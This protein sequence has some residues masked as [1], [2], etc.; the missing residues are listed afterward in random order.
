QAKDWYEKAAEQN[1][2]NAQFNLGMLYYKGEGVKQNFRQ[3]R[4]WFEKAASQN[5]PNAQ[6]NL[7]QIYY[8][9]QGVTQS[10]R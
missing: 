7:G 10:Y 8:Y 9:G 5:Q 2:A 1:F 4:E 3:A 6:Y